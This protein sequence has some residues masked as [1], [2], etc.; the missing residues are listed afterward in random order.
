[1]M[2]R[3]ES[4]KSGELISVEQQR[5]IDAYWRGELERLECDFPYEA[6]FTPAGGQR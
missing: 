3:G 2:R 4:G 6:A 1:M 5:R